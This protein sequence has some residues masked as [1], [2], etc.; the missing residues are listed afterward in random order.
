MAKTYVLLISISLLLVGCSS[1][2]PVTHLKKTLINIPKEVKTYQSAEP[3]ANLIKL[4][5]GTRV[6]YDWRKGVKYGSYNLYIVVWGNPKKIKANFEHSKLIELDANTFSQTNTFQI[7]KFV[8]MPAQPD[9]GY[10]VTIETESY[11]EATPK[12]F[13]FPKLVINDNTYTIP[14]IKIMK[15]TEELCFRPRI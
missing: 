4:E 7:P 5:N 15:T 9:D 1:C 14:E 11:L 13:Q 6:S 8:Q 12:I 10:F 3:T 2:G